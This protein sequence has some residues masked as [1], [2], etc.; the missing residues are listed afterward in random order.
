MVGMTRRWMLMRLWAVLERKI[1][2]ALQ[3]GVARRSREKRKHR[4][5][6]KIMATRPSRPRQGGVCVSIRW[7]FSI[8]FGGGRLVAASTPFFFHR[9]EGLFTMSIHSYPFFL[10]LRFFSGVVKIEGLCTLLRCPLFF[11]FPTRPKRGRLQMSLPRRERERE[12]LSTCSYSK[13]VL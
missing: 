4:C 12:S 5:F 7:L 13:R 9:R 1:K 11:F 8:R 10:L 2:R 3:K 6:G